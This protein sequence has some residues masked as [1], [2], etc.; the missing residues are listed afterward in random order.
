MRTQ[1][2]LV[3]PT[4]LQFVGGGDFASVGQEFLTHFIEL[5]DLQPNDQVLDVGCGVGRMAVPLLDYLSDEGSY[6]GF[7]PVLG[8]VEWCQTHV[9]P[10]HERFSFTHV[11]LYNGQYNPSGS[12]DANTFEFPHSDKS[13]SFIFLTSVFTHLLPD[14]VEQ[15]LLEIERVLQPGGRVLA[16]LLLLNRES[17]SLIEAGRSRV[18][19]LPYHHETHRVANE[20]IPEAV[21]AYD[22]DFVRSLF[23]RTSLKLREPINY[24][25]WCGRA[26]GRSHQDILI[27]DRPRQQAR[28]RRRIS[29]AARASNA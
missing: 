5:C 12:V 8:G 2:Q 20:H 24:G 28:V 13:L 3:P 18:V 10:L 14:A 15:Y 9:Q 29:R 7:D 19:E 11:D 25:T 1:D 27:A 26:V 17:L 16:T 23:A 6:D 21:I 4:E 22:E